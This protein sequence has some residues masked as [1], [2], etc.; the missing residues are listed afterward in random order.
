MKGIYVQS[1]IRALL[2]IVYDG[3]R[4]IF[5]CYESGIVWHGE[6]VSHKYSMVFK[7]RNFNFRHFWKFLKFK[8]LEI[9]GIVMQ[10]MFGMTW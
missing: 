8:I 7:K 3:I 6:K 10:M 9:W 1:S 2:G 5:Q 4:G